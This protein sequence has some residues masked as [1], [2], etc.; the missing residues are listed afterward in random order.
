MGS[1]D[2]QMQLLEELSILSLGLFTYL[3]QINV[4]NIDISVKQEIILLLLIQSS[5]I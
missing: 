4:G 5:H 2:L 3:L 1:L